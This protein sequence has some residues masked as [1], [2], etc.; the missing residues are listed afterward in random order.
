MPCQFQTIQS[1]LRIDRSEEI[2]GGVNQIVDP[3]TGEALTVDGMVVTR[4]HS[5]SFAITKAHT[6]VTDL[7]EERL[8]R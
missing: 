8:G 6:V 5:R 2:V 3:F 4:E 7:A 1:D